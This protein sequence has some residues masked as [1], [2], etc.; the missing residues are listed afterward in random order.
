MNKYDSYNREE[1]YI[2]SHLFR[3]LHENI[4]SKNDGALGSLLSILPSLRCSL[5]NENINFSDLHFENIG[6]YCEVALIRDAYFSLKPNVN[7]FMDNL[8]SLLTEIYNINNGCRK[9]SELPE[10]LSN[11]SKTH[12]EQIKRKA[13]EHG[14][15]LSKNEQE[16]YGTIQ[17]LF[18][19]KPDLLI[20]IDDYLIIIEAKFTRFFDENQ[21]KRTKLIARIWAKLLYRDLGFCSIPKSIVY[22]LGAA[23]FGADISWDNIVK[24]AEDIYPENDRSLIAFKKIQIY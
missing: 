23:Q 10:E 21:L 2:C 17:A 11:C 19:S 15:N 3:L 8:V 6:I 20:T 9:Y 18:R 12:P 16:I 5:Y 4:G 24:I 1:R 7:E 14:I 13:L 22:K